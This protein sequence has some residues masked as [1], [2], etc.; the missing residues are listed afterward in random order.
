M[1]RDA[2]PQ[3]VPA[4]VAM[5]GDL[6]RATRMP[7]DVDAGWAS[8]FVT[9]LL[10]CDDGL[11]LIVERDRLAV[12]MLIASVGQSSVSP[13]RIGVEHGWWCGPEARGWG[14]RLLGD[15]EAWAS[16]RGCVAVRMS[17]AAEIADGAGLGLLLT[18][19]GYRAAEQAWIKVL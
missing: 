15:Y 11:A 17:T 1:I 14:L 8:A 9:A 13:V 7:I 16:S 4:I 19:R 6:A 2:R 5:A 18:R 10:A 12:G 3:D